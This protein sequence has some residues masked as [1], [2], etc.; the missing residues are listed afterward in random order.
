MAEK[1]FDVSDL[2]GL[3][4]YIEKNKDKIDVVAHVRFSQE[5]GDAIESIL[6]FGKRNN[7]ESKGVLINSIEK[8]ES[9]LDKYYELEGRFI[10]RFYKYNV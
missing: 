8:S 6:K 2:E 4:Y 10:D 1:R 5:V 3:D 7:L 9:S